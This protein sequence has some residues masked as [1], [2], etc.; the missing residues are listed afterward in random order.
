MGLQ[1]V[2][3]IKR[4]QASIKDLPNDLQLIR[5]SVLDEIS[6]RET[7]VSGEATTRSQEDTLIRQS[8]TNLDNATVKK[9]ANGNDFADKQAFRNNLSLYTIEEVESAITQATLAMGANYT[10]D[11]IAGRDELVKLTVGDRIL[12]ADD[13]DLK[14]ALYSVA[15]ITNG[16]GSTSTYVKLMD[17]DVLLNA[18]SASAIKAAYES[19]DDTNAFTDVAR[20]KVANIIIT[21]TRDLDKVIQSDEFVSSETALSAGYTGTEDTLMSSGAV[22]AF[23][24]EAARQGGLVLTMDEKTVLS[25]TVSGTEYN[26]VELDHAPQNGLFG[27]FNGICA[28][29]ENN[30]IGVTDFY[31]LTQP[32]SETNKKKFYIA[33]AAGLA[34]ESVFIQ[35]GYTPETV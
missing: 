32:A 34:G 17:Q 12:V 35:Y 2:G 25:E 31:R 13:G 23:A 1:Q 29:Y 20:D 30:T 18:L 6:N 7:A 5:Q 11:D 15:T 22:V 4:S 14:W 10:V 16:N 26:Y 24:K 3:F 33:T 28:I 19:N 9:S 8:V 27:I 21:M